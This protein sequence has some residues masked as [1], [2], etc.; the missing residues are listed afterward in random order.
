MGRNLTC[1]RP[2]L[3]TLLNGGFL[4]LG[5]LPLMLLSSHH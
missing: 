2:I 1:V 5:T 4:R 3:F